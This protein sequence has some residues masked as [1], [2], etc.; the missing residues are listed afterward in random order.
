MVI[1]MM[2]GDKK[3]IPSEIIEK[4]GISLLMLFGSYADGSYLPDSDLDLAYLSKDILSRERELTLLEE[5]LKHYQKNELDLVNLRKASPALKL[6]VATKG[7]LIYGTEVELLSFQLYAS[8]RYADSKFLRL[9]RENYLK[10]R[11]S[12]L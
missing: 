10:K 7:K 2:I 1:I 6:E 4:Y 8:G 9:E 5:L 11:L 12:R 3:D